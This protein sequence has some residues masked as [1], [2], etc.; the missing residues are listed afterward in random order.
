MGGFRLLDLVQFFLPVLPEIESP[1]EK[2][3]FDEKVV[4]TVGGAFIFLLGQLPLY[5]LVSNAQ[6]A[7]VDPLY[8]IRSIFAME[9]GTLLELGLLP[10]ITAAFIWQVAA[11]LRLINANLGLR[12]DRELFQTGQK[13][14]AFAL[15][16]VYAAGLIYS[17]YYDN[18]IRGYDPLKDSTPIGSYV[19]LFTQIVS[20]SWLVTLMVEIFDKGYSFGSGVLSFL[21][22]QVATNTVA[23]LIGIEV[24]KVF[25]SN[26]SE[27]YGALMNLVRNFSLFSPKKNAATIWHAFTRIQLPNLNQFYISLLTIGGVI[28]L[29][30]YRI[31][32]PIRS[33]KVRGMS[34]VFPIRLLYTGGLPVLFAFTVLANVQVFGYFSTVVL[35]KLG[36][37]QLLV[38][39]LGKFELNPTSNNLNLKTGILFYLS[40]STSLLQTLLSPIKTVVY[41]FSIVVL[42]VWF[43]N[44]WSYISGSSPKDIAKQFKDQ[45][46]SI[47][48]KRDISIA[49]ELARVIPVA[50]VSGAF[51]LAGLAVAGELL[52]GLGKGVATVVG[53]SSAFGVLEEFMLEYQQSGGSQFTSALSGLQ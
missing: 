35:S 9:K 36:A 1:V 4:Y 48:G 53:V 11:G 40:N 5:G 52:G 15:A 45:G 8:N 37:P 2:I 39:L 26:K 31:E 23:D 7:I 29:Q 3:A 12:Y 41:A 19:L 49:K 51:L 44:K 20:W 46:I 24:F 10:V 16:V 22:L 33:T 43:A 18:V 32:I 30:N 13:L 17:G 28:L 47:S 34:N 27:S 38:S 25:N 14:T 21:T 6:F 50:S 42:S